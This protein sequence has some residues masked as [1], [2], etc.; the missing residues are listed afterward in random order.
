M[1]LSMLFEACG[2]SGIELRPD[3]V[4]VRVKAPQGIV[5][6]DLREELIRHKPTILALIP[7]GWPVD[8]PLPSWWAELVEVFPPGFLKQAK[9]LECIDSSCRFPV[10][11][12][13]FDRWDR[14]F[15]WSCPACGLEAGCR[16]VSH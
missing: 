8:V 11:V 4:G 2:R 5:T 1:T 9:R 15:V 13:W 3:G 14:R 16:P 7:P 6:P 10:A 12:E